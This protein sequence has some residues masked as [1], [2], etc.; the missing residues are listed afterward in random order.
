MF[1]D[2][3]DWQVVVVV[4]T[5]RRTHILDHDRKHHVMTWDSGHFVPATR[6]AD[7]SPVGLHAPRCESG[8]QKS[9]FLRPATTRVKNAHTK[10]ASR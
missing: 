3:R 4:D 7:R 9:L 8:G 2:A 10:L 6:N 1:L 5:D